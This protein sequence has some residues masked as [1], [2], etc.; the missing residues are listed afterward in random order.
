MNILTF[1]IEEWFIEKQ[2][3]GARSEKYQEFDR[4]LN[5][6]LDLLDETKTRATFFCLGK[7]ATDFPCVV[8]SISE[9]GHEIGCHSN[10]HLWLT[11]MTPEQLRT[12]THDAIAALQDVAGQ[13]VV[14]YRAPAFSIGEQNKWALEI[15]A[16]EGIERDASIF[17]AKRDFGGFDSFP[18][19]SPT[20]IS[21]NGVRLKE[22]PICLASLLGKQVAYSGGGYFRMFPYRLIRKLMKENEYVMT[23]FHIGDFLQNKGG[24]MSKSEYEEYFKEAGTLK[25]RLARYVKSNLGTS[26]AFDKMAHMVNSLDFMS[27]V[28]ADE[29]H[30]WS[31][32][33]VINL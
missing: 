27:L 33:Q 25:N 11:Q 22:F 6:I 32:V 2:F 18:T 10:T 3:D 31:D 17:P 21:Y 9:R 4:Y 1:D 7:I 19:A 13:K 15:L 16:S 29:M 23:Y 5:K 20:I 26:S 8:K 24:L 14:S 28:D 30:D 12:D